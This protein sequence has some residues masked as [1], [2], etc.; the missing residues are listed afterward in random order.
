VPT[1]DLRFRRTDRIRIDVP[2]LGAVGE[3]T[4]EVLDERTEIGK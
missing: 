2:V 1:A 4:A 3:V